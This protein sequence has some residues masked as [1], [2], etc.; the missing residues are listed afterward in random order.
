VHLEISS[1][2][3]SVNKLEYAMDSLKRSMKWDE[4][5]FG[6][7]YDLGFYNIVATSDFN[8]GAMENKGLILTLNVWKG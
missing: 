2:A 8:M 6:L 3:E 5:R 1:K 4:D 7:E